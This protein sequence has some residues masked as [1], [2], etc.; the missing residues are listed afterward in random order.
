MGTLIRAGSYS[1]VISAWIDFNLD[2]DLDDSGE[3]RQTR[4]FS[5][6]TFDGQR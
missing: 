6:Y 5:G 4:V 3:Q 2:G 1:G